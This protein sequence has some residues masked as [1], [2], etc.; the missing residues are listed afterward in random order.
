M[1]I[2]QLFPGDLVSWPTNVSLGLEIVIAV[3]QNV[4][5]SYYVV[6]YVFLGRNKAG[7]ASIPITDH[8]V[9]PWKVIT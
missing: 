9:P 6:Q 4:T 8:V 5:K 7:W 1:T 3:K 2:N